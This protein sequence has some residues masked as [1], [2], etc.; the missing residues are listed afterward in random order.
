MQQQKKSNDRRILFS[1]GPALVIVV[2][3]GLSFLTWQF[4]R[5]P[6]P[7]TLTYGQL[8]QLVKGD[9]PNLK[10]ENVRV[11]PGEVHGKIVTSEAFAPAAPPAAT[12]SLKP[13]ETREFQ[14]RLGLPGDKKL[15]DRLQKRS[16]GDFDRE[17]DESMSRVVA[18]IVPFLMI[19]M[20][21][22][23]GV[24]LF[25]WMSAGNSPF[26]FGRSRHKLYEEKG[27]KVTFENVAGIDEAVAELREIVDFLKTP[28][29]YQALGGRIPK[30]VLLVGPPGTGKTLLARLQPSPA[31]G[32]RV[33]FFSMSGSDFV[34]MFVGVATP[35]RV[36]DVFSQ[37]PKR[38]PPASSSSTSSTPSAK[39]AA[40]ATWEATTNAN[41][42]STNSS[43]RWTASRAIAASS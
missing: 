22:G 7:L 1:G 28:E 37:K 27:T 43:S 8:E 2:L 30:G 38:E 10:F 39:P 15:L 9:D 40:A 33:P 6:G 31:Q 21:L 23:I 19:L 24:V 5:E 14:T 25:R 35:S 29:K 4:Q 20:M 26:S 16:G 36:R 3:L 12:A 13:N 32:R 11:G 42:R 41:R 34:E 18:A 17:P